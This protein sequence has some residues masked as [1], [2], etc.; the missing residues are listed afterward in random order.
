M[1]PVQDLQYQRQE[2][3]RLEKQMAQ[4]PINQLLDRMSQLNRLNETEQL[5]KDLGTIEKNYQ[6]LQE[7]RK[8]LQESI[9]HLH[10]QAVR[11]DPVAPRKPLAGQVTA[12]AEELDLVVISIGRDAGVN[13]GDEFTVYRGRTFVCVVVI[14]RV[15]RAWASG[16]VTK[17]GKEAARVGDQAS[18]NVLATPGRD[19]MD[20]TWP[21]PPPTAELKV[22]GASGA[23][24]M[25]SGAIKHKLEPGSRVMMWRFGKYLSAAQ[26]TE[27]NGNVATAKV[28]QDLDASPLEKGD[29]A[30]VFQ[31]LA[32]I[33]SVL[34]LQVR[35][36]LI[37]KSVQSSL[38][39][40][41]HL[42]RTMKGGGR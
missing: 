10:A 32:S 19:G 35:H 26:V 41:L 4:D 30:L 1:S 28:I 40:K 11:T 2:L 39:V 42:L 5:A 22:L 17:K 8:R 12:V 16:R 18:N 37:S 20:S 6:E 29:P 15:D 21:A 33:W 31:S 3:L 9:A 13:E 25:L 34:P 36:N 14:D 23:I 24:V 27:V 7:A 38:R